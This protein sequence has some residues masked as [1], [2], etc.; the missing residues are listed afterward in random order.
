MNGCPYLDGQMVRIAS[1]D[2]L[3]NIMNNKESKDERK[4]YVD[5]TKDSQPK[6]LVVKVDD[7]V[8]VP[9]IFIES[10]NHLKANHHELHQFMEKH[11]HEK[12]GL[13]LPPDKVK[14]FIDLKVL[15]PNVFGI[16]SS[17]ANIL[18]VTT[19][20][21]GTFKVNMVGVLDSDEN[22]FKR[23]C[24]IALNEDI[25]EHMRQIRENVKLYEAMILADMFHTQDH[26]L[27]D[28]EVKAKW[29]KLRIDVGDMAHKLRI[30][31]VQPLDYAY[32]YANIEIET[33]R[34]LNNLVLMDVKKKLQKA[35]REDVFNKDGKFNFINTDMLNNDFIEKIYENDDD[36]SKTLLMDADTAN[37]DN[38]WFSVTI[39]NDLLSATNIIN[40]YM[41]NIL[42]KSDV[43]NLYIFVG[44]AHAQ[45]LQDIIQHKLADMDVPDAD[46]RVRLSKLFKWTDKKDAQEREKQY[47][48]YIAKIR[49]TAP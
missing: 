27:S 14:Q 26:V 1:N 25:R 20:H 30:R 2:L 16:E 38:F 24:D 17:D 28:S 48:N 8:K 29:D 10:K 41:D 43:V 42:H 32:V 34:Y 11:S 9:T 23:L 47:Q 7:L 36:V 18:S 4:C 3:G 22:Q 15:P 6:T 19:A 39:L 35:L 44:S 33:W 31:Q 13:E 49:Q 21:A 5:V 46:K 37:F 12:I 40:E 45:V